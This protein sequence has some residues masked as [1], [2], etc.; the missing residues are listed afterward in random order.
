MSKNVLIISSSPR[1]GGNSDVLCDEFLKG[2]LE[3]GNTG[4]KLFLR[5]Y[6][7]SYCAGCETCMT[8][9]GICPIKDDAPKIIAKMAA[10]DVIVLATPVYF[11]TMSA[12]LKTLIDRCCAGY[13]QISGKEF[14]FIAT[15][16][17]TNK[18]ELERTIES[19]R[20]FTYCLENPIEKGIIYGT[21]VLHRGDINNTEF[22][23][24][25]I[26]LGRGI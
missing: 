26:E 4:E 24:Q 21:G 12:Q 25:A 19:L 3:A 17:N 22:I 2:A 6:K 10:A 18:D 1:R 15:A 11:Y 8:E 13:Q 5:D 23:N 9:G 20:G 14:Y 7:V 16:E